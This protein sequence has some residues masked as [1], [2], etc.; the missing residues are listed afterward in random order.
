[1]RILVTNDDGMNAAQLIPLVK[2]CK[3]LGEVFCVVP[4]N[5]QSGKSH[6][7]ELHSD[8]EANKFELC[9]GVTAWYVDSTPADCV[10]FAI[11]GLHE[12]FDLVISGIN[13]G[14]NIGTDMIYSGTVGAACEANVLG[15]KALAISVSPMDYPNATADLELVFNFIFNNDL[16][17]RNSIYNI[18][19]PASPKGVLITRQG[20][21][22]Y[23]DD[24]PN[25]SGNIYRPTGK[26]VYKS[27]DDIS[28]D[29]DAVFSGYVSITPITFDRTDNKAYESLSYLNN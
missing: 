9:P 1:M 22:Y 11:L 16:L 15:V 12:K 29:T 18:N 17:D 14:L 19:I 26:C 23:S 28:L 2:F 6:A 4:K 5:E 7:I 25:I 10:R 13:K 27:S 24:F 21:P 8:F 3:E 20:G